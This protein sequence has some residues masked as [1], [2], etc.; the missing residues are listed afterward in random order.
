VSAHEWLSP[1][2]YTALPMRKRT[3]MRVV[4]M[5]RTIRVPA[6]RCQRSFSPRAT[7]SSRGTYRCLGRSGNTSNSMPRL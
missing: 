2:G 3:R 6:V 5:A 7:L 4:F 1:G